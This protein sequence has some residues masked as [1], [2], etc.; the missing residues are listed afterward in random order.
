MKE[1]RPIYGSRGRESV[2]NYAKM[3]LSDIKHNNENTIT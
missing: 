1:R 2:N 3:L